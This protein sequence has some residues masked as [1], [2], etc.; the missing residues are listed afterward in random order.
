MEP[1]DV[2][3]KKSEVGIAPVLKFE[4]GTGAKVDTETMSGFESAPELPFE[5]DTAATPASGTA[6]APSSDA[7]AAGDVAVEPVVPPAP[8][9]TIGE[10]LRKARESRGES[11]N[12]VVAALKLSAAQL[13]A[14]ENDKF[15]SLPGT[16]FTRGFLRNYARHLGLDPEPLLARLNA[17]VATVDLTQV[18]SKSTGN[19][20]MTGARP[21][22]ATV[23]PVLLVVLV[24]AVLAGVAVL[25]SRYLDADGESQA[26][27]PTA[28]AVT[29]S[30]PEP[31]FPPAEVTAAPEPEANSAPA[32]EPAPAA[33]E[34]GE[35]NV[36][37]LAPPVAVS[38]APELTAAP[39]ATDAAAPAVAST[40]AAA[41]AP[42]AANAPTAQVAAAAPAAIPPAAEAAPAAPEEAAPPL[43]FTFSGESWVQ[44][45]ENGGKVIFTRG[46]KRGSASSVFGNP[47]F[48]VVIRNADKVKLEF[49]G[50]PVNLSPHTNRD[51]IARVT[52]K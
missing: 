42:A 12:D 33:A 19:I 21:R 45:R 25:L 7:T 4:S 49:N 41:S 5:S 30:E 26:A 48:S 39:A 46:V 18:F 15:S 20:P 3:D 34:Q 51:G 16:T 2:A 10:I 32:P 11:F 36:V 31:A 28:P 13:E 22:S 52:L 40:P 44:V 47:P 43:R 14:I 24:L 17:P 23:V 1:D 29:E 37:Q 9:E 35:V 8:V 27:A 6:S 38:L 50:K